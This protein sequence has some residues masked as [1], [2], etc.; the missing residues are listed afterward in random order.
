[1]QLLDMLARPSQT[2]DFD[3]FLA[4]GARLAEIVDDPGTLSRTLTATRYTSLFLRI[5][6]T[7]CLVGYG[8]WLTLKLRSLADRERN[9]EDTTTQFNFWVYMH[10]LWIGDSKGLVTIILDMWVWFIISLVG[11]AILRTLLARYIREP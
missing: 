9:G 4:D 3:R 1:M 7:G 10:R 11:F 6:I 2:P 5:A 8:V